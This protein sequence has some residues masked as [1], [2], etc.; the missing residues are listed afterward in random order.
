MLLA[1]WLYGVFLIQS[2]SIEFGPLT[3]VVLYFKFRAAAL[4][5]ETL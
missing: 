1:P 5:R 2:F 4:Q 3:L